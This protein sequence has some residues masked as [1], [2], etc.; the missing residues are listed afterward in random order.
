MTP[1]LLLYQD[2]KL[3]TYELDRSMAEIEELM[4]MCGWTDVQCELQQLISTSEIQTKRA[5]IVLFHL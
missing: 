4:R 5:S 1:D 2:Y 3:S